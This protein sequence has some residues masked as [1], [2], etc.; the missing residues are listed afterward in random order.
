MSYQPRPGSTGDQ[1]LQIIRARGPQR[2]SILAAELG[3][4]ETELASLLAWPMS[5]GGI[6]RRVEGDEWVYDEGNGFEVAAAPAHDALA[7]GAD[8]GRRSAAQVRGPATPPFPT[9]NGHTPQGANRDASA[10]QSHGATGSE[11]PTGRGTNGAP[12]LGAAPV[13]LT[14]KPGSQHVLKAEGASPDATDRDAPA[15]ASP[16]GGPMGAGQAAAAAPSMRCC[17][18]SDG[19]LEIHRGLDE[20][21][22]DKTETLQLVRFLR[23][24]LGEEGVAA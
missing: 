15:H 5:K 24:A 12:A 7:A 11:S 4:S 2:E 19:R 3:K 13:S 1:V 14:T 6:T 16:V 8:I 18:W 17:I 21:A 23:C 10:E 22:L 9:F 20:F